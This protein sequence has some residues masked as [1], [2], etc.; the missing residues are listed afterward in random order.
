MEKPIEFK[1]GNVSKLREMFESKSN[2]DVKIKNSPK[3]DI[4]KPNKVEKNNIEDSK[5]NNTKN[6]PKNEKN[7]LVGNEHRDTIGDMK[8]YE[9]KKEFS[10]TERQNAKRILFLGNAQK[11]FINTF[12]N[13]FRGI[14]FKENFR[15]KIYEQ[16]SNYDISSFINSDKIRII[17]IPFCNEKNEKYVKEFLLE[18]SKMK[19]YLVCYT[20]DK[21]INGLTLEQKKEIEFYKYLI[22]YLGLKEKLIFLCDSKEELKN[23]EIKKFLDKFNI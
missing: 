16:R 11:S 5:L 21:N 22:H 2:K 13:I 17:S 6:F 15:H 7:K 20:F 9:Y 14:E 23:E 18:I 10:S 19:I 12:I 4:K 8:I 3:K 1:K